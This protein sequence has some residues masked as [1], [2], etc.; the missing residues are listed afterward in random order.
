[1]LFFGH[2]IWS[3]TLN[4]ADCQL[5]M[6]FGAL[7]PRDHTGKTMLTC[8]AISQLDEHVKGGAGDHTGVRREEYLGDEG[9]SSVQ[10]ASCSL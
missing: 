5:T 6:L 2:R 10:G 8:S 4:R 1:M 7:K 3:L 9:Q